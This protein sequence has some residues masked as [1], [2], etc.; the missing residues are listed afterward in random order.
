MVRPSSSRIRGIITVIDEGRDL[1]QQRD[2]PDLAEQLDRARE[3]LGDRAATVVVVG[4][5]KRGK[6]TL[7]NALLQTAVCPVD[8]DIVTSVPTVVT[9]GERAAAR[10]EETAEDGDG[11]VTR[12]ANLG[13]I[14]ALVS[15]TPGRPSRVRSVEVRVPHRILRS[16]LRLVDTPGV[17]GLDSAHGQLS[18]GALGMAGG[19]LFVTDAAQELTGPE[20]EFLQTAAQRCEHTALVVTKIDLYPQWRRIVELDEQHVNRAGLAIPVVPVSS[21]LRLRAAMEPD[22]NAEAG[23]EPLVRV[24]AGGIVGPEVA[25]ATVV[26]AEEVDQVVT[27]LATQTDAERV[28]LADPTSAG[29]VIEKL[30]RARVRASALTASSATWQQ[31][32]AD[33]IQDLVADVEHDLQRRLREVARGVE[34]VIDA[35]DP[36]DAWPDIETW[37]HRQ[38]AVVAVANRELLDARATELTRDVAAQF[39]LEA[40]EG[41][42]LA[43]RDVSESLVDLSLAPAV[44][45]DAKVG[46][47]GS[48]VVAARSTVYVPM[49]LFGLGSALGV[50]VIAAG[51]AVALGAGIGQKIVRDEAKRQRMHRQQQG[52][53]AA[54]KFLDEV[55]FVMNKETRDGLRA[56]QRQ[57]RDDFQGRASSLHRSA[58]SALEVAQRAG[59]IERADRAVREAELLKEAD[60]LA[61]V[62]SQ[63]KALAVGAATA[64]GV[65]GGVA[66]VAAADDDG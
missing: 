34:S 18:L 21:F 64:T 65:M 16:G 9:Y 36:K 8:A 49:L 35:G 13:E 6:S 58:R 59:H 14:P 51:V 2:R 4:E 43:L 42:D 29:E 32:L 3:R 24:L 15:E 1:A 66:V 47:I 48:L 10:V 54:R 31:V 52:K 38:V 7:V 57:L 46:R 17:G 26:A 12:E 5:F 39:D 56:T 44:S 23:F 55:A 30:D 28:V 63:A 25:R 37:L 53:V 41:V 45:L 50:G 40:G 11:V 62:R 33:G 60:R 19:A 61:R 20:L 27:Q 22:L